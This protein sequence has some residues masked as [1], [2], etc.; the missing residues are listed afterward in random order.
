MNVF[1]EDFEGLDKMSFVSRFKV[2]IKFG[3]DSKIATEAGFA[4]AMD[5]GNI[6]NAGG[7]QLL[8]DP[9]NL[10]LI[11]HGNQLFGINLNG[12]EE[13]GGPATGGDDGFGDS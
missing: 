4:M 11:E 6:G 13:A 3:V 1:L 12:G 5:D 10:G 2:F 8:N 7:H 9:L